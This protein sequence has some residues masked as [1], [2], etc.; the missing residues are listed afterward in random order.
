MRI[1]PN[2]LIAWGGVSKVYKK[3]ETIFFED[4]PARFYFQILQ[5]SVKMSNLNDE[6]KE[7]T[8]GMFRA[9]DSFGEPPL[10]I[11]QNYPASA[12]TLSDSV[13]IKLSKDSFFKVLD[14]YPAVQM[15]F[16][17]VFAKRIF[18]KSKTNSAIA[19]NDPANRIIEFLNS[20]KND[21]DREPSKVKI[22]FTRQEIANFTGL[23]VETVIRTLIRMQK[24]KR[25]EIIERKIF[26]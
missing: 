6:G 10:F 23:R 24:E 13:I 22:P 1:D 19:N 3:N 2:I 16:L 14:A 8:Q 17:Q 11:N 7:F 5:G 25:V 26:Y 9:G 20:Y 12:T 4:S 21:Q 15:Q 18:N